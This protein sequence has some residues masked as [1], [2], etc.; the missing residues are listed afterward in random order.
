MASSG[1][2]SDLVNLPDDIKA[3]IK[4]GKN[5]KA[6][7]C[8]RCPSLILKEQCGK[9]VHEDVSAQIPFMIPFAF[10]S[11]IVDKVEKSIS[12]NVNV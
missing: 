5:G 11:Y 6:L 1:D 2:D 9:F 4:D 8:Q 12:L 10:F 3:V 7:K